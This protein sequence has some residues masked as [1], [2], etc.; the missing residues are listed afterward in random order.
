MK[1]IHQIAKKNGYPT[2]IIENRNKTDPK[3]EYK[4]KTKQP[5]DKTKQQKMGNFR[6]LHP[7]NT[8]SNQYL[9]KYQ[10]TNN[11]PS[12]KYNTTPIENS[13]KEFRHIRK[14]WHIQFTM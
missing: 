7:H 13:Q 11:I 2:T 1:T 12:Q 4:G 8:E 3:Q 6:I 10:F 5:T 14:Q 9:Q